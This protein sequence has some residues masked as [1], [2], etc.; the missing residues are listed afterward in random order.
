MGF[1]E[2]NG[3]YQQFGSLLNELRK[4]N[5]S[6]ATIAIALVNLSAAR[7]VEQ[8]CQRE[9]TPVPNLP[10]DLKCDDEEF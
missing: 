8:D 2:T 4:L 5:D 9:E 7:I 10:E 6:L 1:L 3:D